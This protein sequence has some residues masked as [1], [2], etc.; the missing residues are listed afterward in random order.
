MPLFSLNYNAY[1][2]FYEDKLQ[3]S[4]DEIRKFFPFKFFELIVKIGLI[5]SF[6]QLKSG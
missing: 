6:Q 4:T 1:H 5:W 3:S 2:T